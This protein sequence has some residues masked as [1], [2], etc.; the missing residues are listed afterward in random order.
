MDVL[1][2]YRWCR[3]LC[4]SSGS[5]FCWTFV[6]LPR[7][8]CDAMNALYAFARITDDIGDGPLPPQSKRELLEN[9]LRLTQSL[10]QSPMTTS[11]NSANASDAW[12]HLQPALQHAVR[13]FEIPVQLLIDIVR[14]VMM[15]LE[16]RMPATGPHSKLTVTTSH[17]QSVLHALEFGK[18]MH[19]C[20]R[21][22]RSTVASRFS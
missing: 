19:R 13:T 10:D 12:N 20:L 14:G 8:Q 11:E 1:T 6:L 5:S 7:E 17:P 21:K 9:W 3:R 16:H 2:S 4:R 15:D 18:R 22:L